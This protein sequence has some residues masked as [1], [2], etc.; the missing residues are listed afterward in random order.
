MKEFLKMAVGSGVEFGAAVEAWQKTPSKSNL[1]EVLRHIRP[2]VGARAGDYPTIGREIATAE[3]TRA[4]LKGL[5]KY[6]PH[7]G[8]SP[9]TWTISSMRA[10]NRQLLR[11]ATPLRIPDARLQAVG[12]MGRAEETGG[13]TAQKA[14]RS[15]LSTKDYMLLSKESRP[16]LV[17][18]RE[19]IPH[20]SRAPK[21]KETWALLK[22]ELTDREKK[23]HSYLSANPDMATNSIAKKM[24]VSA[25]SVSYYKKQIRDKLGRFSK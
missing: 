15:K 20:G 1:R 21:T 24:G 25:S 22:H 10:A 2:I 5:R 14:K 11:R 12:R 23:V 16:V 19:E 7:K 17:A 4:A 3:Y 13:T 18:S 9:K 8:S 6:E